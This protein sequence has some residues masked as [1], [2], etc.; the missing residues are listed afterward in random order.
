MSAALLAVR[1]SAC[2]AVASFGL[3]THTYTRTQTLTADEDNDDGADD[4]DDAQRNSS[5]F[6]R[7]S[8]SPLWCELE[9]G[10]PP[11]PSEPSEVR[12]SQGEPPTSAPS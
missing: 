10:S 4:D 1:R 5:E 8:G 9:T 3:A 6:S 7:P 12:G 11:P 2:S